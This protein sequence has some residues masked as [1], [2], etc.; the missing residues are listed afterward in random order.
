MGRLLRVGSATP[1]SACA[2]PRRETMRIGELVG[3]ALAIERVDEVADQ[4]EV[5]VDGHHNQSVG[6]HKLPNREEQV[7]AYRT[8]DLAEI[9]APKWPY[10]API[11]H[12]FD[13]RTFGINAWRGSAGDSVITPHSEADS[14]AP[15]LYVVVSGHASF[16]IAGEDV[17]APAGTLVW[18]SDAT[19]ERRATASE[20]GTLVLSI[21]GAAPGRAYEP[22]GWDTGYL[23]A[24]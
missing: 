13:I 20:D 3:A 22:S 12:H 11:R 2:Q 17:D 1:E 21:G 6:Y 14:G 15:E 16:A 23:E 5:R 7:S 18:V 24:E 8:A 4:L 19:A 10:W 9:V